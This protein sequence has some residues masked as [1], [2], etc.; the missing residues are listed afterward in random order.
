[1]KF[2]NGKEYLKA[3]GFKP[4]AG[5]EDAMAYLTD[6]IGYM[7][8]MGI[9]DVVNN[10]RKQ[11]GKFGD[12]DKGEI[13]PKKNKTLKMSIAVTAAYE[14][15][16]LT[17]ICDYMMD[18]AEVF[19][20]TVLDIGCDCGILSCFIAAQFPECTVVGVDRCAQAIPNAEEL[21]SSL[22]LTNV[23]FACNTLDHLN[24]TYDVV[25]SSRTLM[26]NITVPVFSFWD[27]TKRVG[28]IHCNAF[29]S[30]ANALAS[31]VK[32][33]GC[34]VSIERLGPNP[35]TLGWIEALQNANLTICGKASGFMVTD[36]DTFFASISKKTSAEKKS[37][38]E[39]YRKAI[40][41]VIIPNYKQYGSFDAMGMLY[42]YAGKLIKG[43][44]IY[45]E[46]GKK[47]I[48]QVLYECKGDPTTLLCEQQM[49][50]MI[51]C[52]RIDNTPAILKDCIRTLQDDN[53]NLLKEKK[54][55]RIVEISSD[56]SETDVTE[57]FRA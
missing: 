8:A 15:E 33:D 17:D 10:R 46:H 50:E 4:T 11:T 39:L 25:L 6:Q 19:K 2:A 28:E 9:L 1:M 26:E 27:G 52:S 12:T 3:I 34:L 51:V 48:K 16:A 37:A 32:D 56:G 43:Y 5:Y 24:E 45:D 30:Y 35:G 47:A 57:Q 31:H 14:T 40:S 41:E 53:V 7:K 55:I 20:G 18:H 22:G 13:Y 36:D 38:E 44:C 23:S 21:A 49:G 54:S 29:E 42:L